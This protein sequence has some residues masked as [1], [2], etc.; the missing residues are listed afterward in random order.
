MSAL[1]NRVSI[2][3]QSARDGLQDVKTFVPT[4]QKARLLP[5][6]GAHTI[7]VASFVSPKWVPQMAGAEELLKELGPPPP[8]V[9]YSAVAPKEKALER[10]LALPKGIRPAKIGVPASAG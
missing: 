10:V 2:T 5:R 4:A 6:S 8:G 3:E 9:R 7:S 1:P